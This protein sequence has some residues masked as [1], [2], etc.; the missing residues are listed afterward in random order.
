MNTDEKLVD[1]GFE[2]LGTWSDGEERLNHGLPRDCKTGPGLY[3]F[4]LS[5]R[6]MYIG[7]AGRRIIHRVQFYGKPGKG[8]AT[9]I[10]VN[11]RIAEAL[12]L[13]QA[14]EIYILRNWLPIQYKGFELN[15]AAGIED[16]LI[17]YFDCPWNALRNG[18]LHRDA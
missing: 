2:R 8:Q 12:A 11:G 6:V 10:R 18:Q 7:K 14:V 16:A 4:V 17:T 1:L 5:N 15:L 3:A 13:G 9:N